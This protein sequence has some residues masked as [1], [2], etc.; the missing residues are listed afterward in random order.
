[1]LAGGGIVAKASRFQR[2]ATAL[3]HDARRSTSIQAPRRWHASR[4]PRARG[5]AEEGGHRVGLSARLGTA[6]LYEYVPQHLFDIIFLL[7]ERNR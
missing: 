3:H 5:G 6:C 4:E 2:R 1:M 7:L